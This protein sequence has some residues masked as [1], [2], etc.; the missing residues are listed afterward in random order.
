MDLCMERLIQKQEIKQALFIQDRISSK[1]QSTIT[2]LALMHEWLN[3][4]ENTVKKTTYQK[5]HSIV[6]NH[7]DT[8]IFDTLPFQ[9]LS[10]NSYSDYSKSILDSGV[11]SP[12]TINVILIFAC[13]CLT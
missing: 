2:L 7:I 4:I 12:K 9:Y 5:Y 1:S 13:H 11:L 6:K 10:A 8:H 3:H